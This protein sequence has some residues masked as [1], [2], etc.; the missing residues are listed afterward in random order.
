[1][2]RTRR[3]PPAPDTAAPALRRAGALAL[4]ASLAL[5]GCATVEFYAQAVAGQ[6]GLLLS[7]RDAQSVIDD[8]A[9]SPPVAAKLRLVRE[10]VDYGEAA[11][12]LDA[13]GS[14]GSYVAVDG[15]PVWL[16][17]AAGEFEVA[18]LPRCYPIVG[19]AIYR[20]YF[21]ERGAR[22]EAARLAAAGYD[23]HVAGAAAYS[24]LGW[25]A[26]PVFSSFLAYD[27]AALAELLFHELAHQV[28]Y[29][30]DD[31]VFNESFANFVGHAGAVQW[32]ADGGGNV[33]AYQAAYQAR[34]RNGA[35]YA[36]FLAAWRERLAAVYHE[37]VHP[38]VKRQAKADALAAMRWCYRRHRAA[39]GG[40]AFDAAMAL[41]YNNARLALAGAY[42]G[43]QPAFETLFRRHRGDWP[44]FYDAVRRLAARPPA[45]RDAQL[46]TLQRNAARQPP[47]QPLPACARPLG[48]PA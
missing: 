15:H 13:N 39:L 46:E 8:P 6:A 36:A 28:V 2:R 11:L 45:E 17:V 10:L 5:A 21:S 20:G 25:F 31:S 43:W 32:L 34:M 7:R 1:M 27:D 30:R 37:P 16:V 47:P 24:T 22:R 23:I 38:S 3:P 18:A 14:F 19:C 12:A 48:A 29:V 44:M 9:T 42:E 35:L 40:G 41:P 33:P 26:D 4:A